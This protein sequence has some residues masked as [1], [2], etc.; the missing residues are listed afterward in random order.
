MVDL[1]F[2]IDFTSAPT[3]RKPIVVARALL[4]HQD[5]SNALQLRTDEAPVEMLQARLVANQ[6]RPAGLKLL[7]FERFSQW[8]DYEAF[9][10][11]PTPVL[12]GPDTIRAMIAAFD[13]PFGLP[14]GLLQAWH[15]NTMDYRDISLRFA[16]HSRQ[17]WVDRLKAFCDARPVGK[18]FAHRACDGPAGSSPSMKWVNPPVVFMYREGFLRLIQAKWALPGFSQS[19]PAAQ[20]PVALEAYPGHLARSALGKLSYKSDSDPRDAVRRAHREHLL[21]RLASQLPID[22]QISPDDRHAMI[23]DGQGDLI[24]AWMCAIQAAWAAMKGPPRWGVPVDL[25]PQEGWITSLD[26]A[27]FFRDP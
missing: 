9:L 4:S 14:K 19:M 20:V 11:A 2:G 5:D 24:D 22:F 27:D 8:Q 12:S 3:A 7:K 26:L 16:E 13:F 6:S 25:D 1:V 23:E 17:Y 15:W 18:K 10:Q 21:E